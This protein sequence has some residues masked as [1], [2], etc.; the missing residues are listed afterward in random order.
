MCRWAERVQIEKGVGAGSSVRQI[1]AVLGRSVST[2][3]REIGLEQVGAAEPELVIPVC[4]GMFGY[5]SGPVTTMQ[6][7]AER[8]EHRC[9]ERASSSHRPRVFVQDRMVGVGDRQ[10]PGRVDTSG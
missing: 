9:R 7:R 1:V 6:Y 8:A 5:T 3:S 2:V 10:T 4:S